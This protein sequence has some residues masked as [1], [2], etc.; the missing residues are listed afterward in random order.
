MP[1]VTRGLYELLITE[2]LAAQLG[3]LE[4]ALEPLREA[5]RPAEAPDRIA[6]HLSRLVHRALEALPE[7][8]RV[9]AAVALTRALLGPIVQTAPDAGAEGDAIREPAEV[10]RHVAALRPDGNPEAIP[11]PL[12][13]LLDTTLLTNAPG[14][15][16][17]GS[18]IATE[19][20]SADRIDVVM[21]FIRRSGI[22]PLT[23]ALR[24]HTE[25]GRPLRVLTTTYTGSTEAAA[26]DV[27]QRIGA[28]VRVS[29]DTDSTR[30]HAKAWLF[31]RRSGFSTA[32]IG[33]SSLT[34]TAQSTGLEWNV[35]LSEARNR[36]V[37][38]KVEAV[39][40]S[41]WSSGDFVPYERTT[42]LDRTRM[43]PAG[44]AV[45][46]SPIEVRLE[47][48]QERLLEQIELSRQRGHHRNLLAAATGTGKT[49]MAAVDYSRLRERLPRARLLFVAH[50]EEIL[51]Q[52]IATFR[53]C[54][55][56][57]TFGEKWVGGARPS[58]FEH[59]FA[60]I[61]SLNA[62]GLDHLAP[63]HFDVVIVDE[64][65]HAAAPSYR[66]LLEHVRPT[67]LLG[68]TATPER[69]DGL[70]VLEWFDNRIAAELRLW[71]AIDQHR[72]SPFVYYGIHDGTDL[73]EVPWVRGR[74]YDVDGLS[75]LL[76]ATDAWSKR[77]LSE[78]AKHVDDPSRMRALGF[79][80]SVDHARYMARVF[81]EVGVRATAV[82]ADSPDE[83]RRAA[84]R[85]LA[86]RKINVV[87]SV[88]LFNE[89]V[90]VPAVDTLL[91]LRPTDSPTLFLQQLGRGLR[92]AKDK[93][94]CTV[95]DFVGRHRSE[96]RF[97]RR[98]RAL[99]GGSRQ[100]VIRQVDAGFPFLPAGCHMELDR[101]ASEIVLASIKG[102]VPSRWTAK[103][104]ELRQIAARDPDVTLAR[105]LAETGLELEDV[106]SGIKGRCSWSDL[107]EAA[108]LP[109]LAAGPHEAVLRRAC[110]R[111]LH[112]DDAVR[113]EAYRRLLSTAEP[114]NI[115]TLSE[116]DRRLLRML[117]ASLA[118]AALGKNTAVDEAAALLWAH[119]QVRREF[120]ELL[121]V[122]EARIEHVAL[123]LAD[124]PDVPL[125]VHA[126]Y[127]RVEI[128]A[129][130][131]VG[132]G[133]KVAP[134][135]T[136]VYWAEEAK[137]DLFAFTLDKT[138][139]L[140]SP[141][142]RYQDYAIS[143][144][145]IH[146][147]SQSVTREDS[148]TGLRYRNHKAMGTSVML[149]A[150]LRTD[151]RAFSFLGPADYVSH[152]GELPM[153]ITWRLRFPLPGDLFA[154]FAAAVA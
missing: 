5:L 19:I 11:L 111:V 32:Y 70:P 45:L 122:Q 137:A 83:E 2:A 12:I 59:V 114:P 25:A 72:L 97:D 91:L 118:N 103:A 76:T 48:F 93:T 40:E 57:A 77:V 146:W 149:F 139:G 8:E 98:F 81:N 26:L 34:H 151:D 68:L 28:D 23:E 35:R 62:V 150:R 21:A 20:Y 113:L 99:L 109:V 66:A 18:Q 80:V 106:Y 84:L 16:R 31:H 147:Q 94:V 104:E 90:D 4:D 27:L 112:I 55:R 13:P 24:Q 49:V 58:L 107:R 53:H 101:V 110:G 39:F 133:A 37:I 135:Q 30:L 85:D 102:A 78:L 74:G 88:D 152:E 44:P 42:F 138:S 92:R 7:R 50:R 130:F 54:L 87:F 136:G 14:E 140:F 148:H 100:D 65:H 95:L 22:H 132:G 10:L 131:G 3:T 127:S 17:V 144:D 52:S 86:G 67:E 6:L 36:D 89:G 63:D 15:P 73:R 96:F 105:Y 69:S 56:E 116:R 1:P 29:Y 43:E 124:Q 9:S 125:Q 41:Y 129:A 134:W 64:F 128:L 145:L 153:S 33:S 51:D 117:T 82:W 47:P 108:G 115:A 71:D 120:L 119:P 123:P 60:S 38:R 141:T 46:L 75:K 154:A 121:D 142:T 61:Q 126:R 143:R 79:C